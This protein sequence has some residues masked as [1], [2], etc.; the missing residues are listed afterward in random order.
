MPELPGH[1]RREDRRE[2]RHERRRVRSGEEFTSEELAAGD[3][4]LE[5]MEPSGPE[6]EEA[7]EPWAWGDKK[8]PREVLEQLRKYREFIASRRQKGDDPDA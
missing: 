1:D 3:V 8:A 6:P 5:E 4:E 7:S 2:R